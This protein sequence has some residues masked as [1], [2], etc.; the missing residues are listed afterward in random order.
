MDEL[1]Y[2]SLEQAPARL[3]AYEANRARAALWAHPSWFESLLGVDQVTLTRWRLVLA[4]SGEA[5]LDACSRAFVT[6]TG[7]PAPGSDAWNQPALVRS[8]L[9]GDKLNMSLLDMLPIEISLQVLSMRALLFRRLELRRV[10]DKRV[11]LRL[12]EWAGV[13]LDTLLANASYGDAPE[14]IGH[15]SYTAMPPVDT[16]TAYTLA[17]EGLALFIRDQCVS[18][19]PQCPLLRLAFA[20]HGAQHHWLRQV[21]ATLDAKGSAWLYAQLHNWLGTWAWLFG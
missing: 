3:H 6:A 1:S 10:I 8:E 2:H 13:G 11:R 7:T 9:H 20:L 17:E 18:N 19:E 15:T 16:L 14:A 12:S 5:M 21:P 4:Q